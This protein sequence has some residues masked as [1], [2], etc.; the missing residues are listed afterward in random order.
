[1]RK[2]EHKISLIQHRFR[3]SVIRHLEIDKML[4]KPYDRITITAGIKRDISS[5]LITF[6]LVSLLLSHVLLESP[7]TGEK[8]KVQYK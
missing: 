3:T 7:D 4:M 1:M 5:L 6:Q 8:V 2:I